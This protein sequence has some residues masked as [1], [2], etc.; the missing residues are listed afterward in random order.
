[1]RGIHGSAAIESPEWTRHADSVPYFQSRVILLVKEGWSG[2]PPDTVRA[3]I[4]LTGP[5]C[6]TRFVPGE[7]YLV[8]ADP[9]STGYA[10]RACTRTTVLD[11]EDA[12]QYLKALG[13]P[14]WRRP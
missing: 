7:R 6:P 1:V 13:P 4:E 11:S 3:T 5:D 9:D 2:A 12:Q 14:R 10:I 8:F